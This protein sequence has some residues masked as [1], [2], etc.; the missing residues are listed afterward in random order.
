VLPGGEKEQTPLWSYGLRSHTEGLLKKYS[1]MA[2][3]PDDTLQMVKWKED[4]FRQIKESELSRRLYELSNVWLS[5]FFGNIVKD[6][7]YYELQNHLSP[8]KFPDW[9]GL[10]EKE[11]FARAQAL[12]SEK[13]FFHWELEF[14]EAFQGEGRGFDVVI[15]NPPYVRQEKL[16]ADKIYFKSVF[17]AYHSIAD[18]YVY[19]FERG[20]QVLRIGGTFGFISSN[21]FMRSNYG[22]PLREYLKDGISIR[23]I[24]DFGELPIFL[25][26]STFPAIY[27]TNKSISA[28]TTIY[29]KVR[30]LDFKTLESLVESQGLSLSKTD[31]NGDNWSLVENDEASIMKKMEQNSIKLGKYVDGEINYGIKSGLNEAFIIDQYTRDRLI[32]EDPKSKEIIKPILVGDDIRKYQINFRNRYLIYIPWHF[33]LNDG[34]IKGSSQLAESLFKDQYPSIFGHLSKYRALLSRRNS[35]EVG[36]RHEWYALQRFASDYYAD[37]SRPKIVYPDIGMTCR[38]A[39]DDVGYVLDT[40]CF[41][42][43]LVDMYLLSLLNSR[44]M[45][46]NIRSRTPVLGDAEKGGRLRFKR[47]YLAN[48]PIRRISFTTPAPERARL[49]A[50]LEQLYADGKTADILAAVETCLPKDGEGNFIADQE[51]SD[52]VHDLLAFLAERMLEMNRQK[53][54]EIKGFL[55]WLEGYVGAKV[56]DLTPKT[57]LQS[58]YEHDYDGFLAVLK[59]NKKK[60]TVD[61]ARRE[62]AEALRAEFEGSMGKLGP[63]QEQ[64]RQTDELIDQVVYRLY[65]LTEEEIKI[66]E[67]RAAK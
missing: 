13:R 30:S 32:A 6:D 67:G 23:E 36:I 17:K 61:P 48:L 59:K 56:E 11:W 25:E 5:T 8:E 1:L 14:P 20:H 39:L 62:P 26:A 47:V 21:K 55:G 18:L 64:I 40:T 50:E 53:Q 34:S 51:K 4:Q 28:D 7:D 49:G 42:I 66:V 27:L 52:V 33:P 58:Y 45:F 60:L 15:G 46:S 24:I 57:K 29:T 3:L 19:F 12:A 41:E 38:F 10:R 35:A 22:R 54:Q 2:A 43:P 31:F 65:G 16:S 9:G 63:L 44:L 37:F